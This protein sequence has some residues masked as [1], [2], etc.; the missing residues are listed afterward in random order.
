MEPQTQAWVQLAAQG[1]E[2]LVWFALAVWALQHLRERAWARPAALGAVLM[3]VP[4]TTL[5]ASRAQLELGG[6]STILEGYVLSS[7]PTVYSVLEV[8]GAAL[9]LLALVL[10]SGRATRRAPAL[11]GAPTT[12]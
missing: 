8:V 11:A 9:L 2:T 5:T 7:L 12:S 4:A 1:L 6:S 3:L 10:R